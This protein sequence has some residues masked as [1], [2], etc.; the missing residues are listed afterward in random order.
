MSPSNSSTS[1]LAFLFWKPKSMFIDHSLVVLVYHAFTTTCLNANTASWP[2]IFWDRAWRIFS[3]IAAVASPS[4]Q[5]W[6]WP[7]SFSVVLS[8]STLRVSSIAMWSL[9]ISWWVREDVETRSMSRIW[10]LPQKAAMSKWRPILPILCGERWL[11][12][13]ILLALTAI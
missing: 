9:V 4:K 10:V 13:H 6:C 1:P 12:Q 11:A 5:C 7:S 3:I 2:L 8:S